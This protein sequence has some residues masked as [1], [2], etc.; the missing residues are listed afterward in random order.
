MYQ[1]AHERSHAPPVFRQHGE[2]GPPAAPGEL[3]EVPFSGDTDAEAGNLVWGAFGL[4]ECRIY[5][6]E[7]VVPL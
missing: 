2:Y 3:V 1:A 4:N 7:A 5:E 6:G